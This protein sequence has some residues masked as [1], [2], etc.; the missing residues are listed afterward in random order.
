MIRRGGPVSEA[1]FDSQQV[2]DAVVVVAV[3]VV[4]VVVVEKLDTFQ[5]ETCGRSCLCRKKNHARESE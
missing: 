1:V 5:G 3:V 4:V 2:S